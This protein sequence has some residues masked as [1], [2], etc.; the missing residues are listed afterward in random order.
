MYKI[1]VLGARDTV[2]CFTALGLDTFPADTV[3]EGVKIFHTLTA[4]GGG[5]SYAVIYIEEKIAAA[6]KSEI[7]RFK[8]S[9]VPA[10]ILIP[11]RE[12]SLGIGQ[13]ALHAAVERAVGSDIL[14]TS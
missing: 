14:K 2:M 3:E 6:L 8:D 4:G 7:A 11:G 5:D 1:A 10:I 12:G 13:T 9:P